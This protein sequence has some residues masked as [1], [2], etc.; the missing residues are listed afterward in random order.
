MFLRQIALARVFV[1]VTCC[2]GVQLK[3]SF[4]ATTL[5]LS[6]LSHHSECQFLSD[7]VDWCRSVP[8][9]CPSPSQGHGYS[10]C[11][12]AAGLW[13]S[14]NLRLSCGFAASSLSAESFV[15]NFDCC[16]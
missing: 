7:Q 6:D 1:A 5:A 8:L 3:C 16:R 2:H 4:S 14:R 13:Q 12:G 10:P 11:G 15:L 9:L